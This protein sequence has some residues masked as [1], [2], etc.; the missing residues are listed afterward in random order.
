MMGRK[1]HI[2]FFLFGLTTLA[3]ARWPQNTRPFARAVLEPKGGTVSGTVDFGEGPEGLLVRAYL[4][5]VPPGKHGFHIH[6]KGD[7]SAPDASSAG[8]HYNPTSN[9]HGS[10]GK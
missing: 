5:H 9:N 10:P 8:D 7:C 3:F 2:T 1:S 4:D 6:E